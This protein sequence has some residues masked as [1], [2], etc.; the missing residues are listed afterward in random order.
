MLCA[1]DKH[2]GI[3]AKSSD[4]I[5]V[6]ISNI[7][8]YIIVSN[9]CTIR[10][11]RENISVVWYQYVK[12]ILKCNRQMVKIFRAICACSQICVSLDIKSNKQINMV[13]KFQRH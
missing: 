2:V 9:L 5:L 11:V 10:F 13:I 12:V 6:Q 8:S 7:K 3:R 4:I 1:C